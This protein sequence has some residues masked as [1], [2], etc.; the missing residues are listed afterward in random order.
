LYIVY[1]VNYARENEKFQV[2][3][4][5]Q[6]NRKRYILKEFLLLCLYNTMYKGKIYVT[7]LFDSCILLDSPYHE[8]SRFTYGYYVIVYTCNVTKWKTIIVTSKLNDT[9]CDCVF[10]KRKL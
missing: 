1:Y 9:K 7:G 10:V 6:S 5:L 4:E 8:R 2:Y 3:T